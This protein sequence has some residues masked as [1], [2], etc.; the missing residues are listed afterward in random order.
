MNKERK[1][2]EVFTATFK[3]KVVKVDCCKGCFFENTGWMAMTDC[4]QGALNCK[5][6]ESPIRFV[7]VKDE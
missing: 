6:S 1:I 3:L 2:G 4:K 5:E 7:E